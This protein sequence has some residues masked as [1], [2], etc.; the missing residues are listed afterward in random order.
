MENF[1]D[2][3]V[4]TRR[5]GGNFE[6]AE[7]RVAAEDVSKGV[8][9]SQL[10]EK[11]VVIDEIEEET[12][13]VPPYGLHPY[14]YELPFSE[15]V[16]RGGQLN[17]WECVMNSTVMWSWGAVLGKL[18]LGSFNQLEIHNQEKWD[19]FVYNRPSDTPLVTVANHTCNIDDPALIA[20]MLKYKMALQ[21]R[22]MRWT[23]GARE[24]M[25]DKNKVFDWLFANGKVIPIIRGH[26]VHQPAMNFALQR[27]N[28][29]EWV[30]I[31]P[32]GKVTV[33]G[34]GR[35]KWGVGRLLSECK[36]M[37][38]VVPFW[39]VGMENYLFQTKRVPFA[40]WLPNRKQKMTVVVGDPVE[41]EHVLDECRQD[42]K[43]PEY[44]RKV[45][46]ACIEAKFK[47]LKAKAEYLHATRLAKS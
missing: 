18:L 28:L 45:V 37:P 13:R 44:T 4:K 43:P 24:I 16:L 35:L 9:G 21:A 2:D 11:Q 10:R 30:H 17:G 47:D 19:R 39:H 26:G 1:E 29:G 20:C 23:L 31:F 27:L 14:S 22:K 33:E 42:G 46:T 36:K 25:F 34:T 12:N 8:V 7:T 41:Y 32:E 5:F 40:K 38:I 3:R 6:N 15:N